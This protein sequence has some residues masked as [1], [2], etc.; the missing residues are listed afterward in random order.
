[1]PALLIRI[2][3]LILTFLK[4]VGPMFRYIW[5]FIKMLGSKPATWFLVSLYPL[6][7]TILE[8]ITGKPSIL[9]QILTGFITST[10]NGMLGIFPDVDLQTLYGEI[11]AQVREVCCYLG[12]TE[13]LQILFN[14]IVTGMVFF[15]VIKINLF[16]KILNAKIWARKIGPIGRF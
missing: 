1:M 12:I 15:L 5:S 8:F 6:I 4:I 2:G 11:P 13:S 9:T 16:I 3:M 7:S 10:I 14:G